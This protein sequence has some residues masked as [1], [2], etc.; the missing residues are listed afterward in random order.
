MSIRQKDT[1][2]ARK[3]LFDDFL[4]TG[5]I[6][7]FVAYLLKK[8]SCEGI[9]AW[10]FAFYGF[11]QVLKIRVNLSC[12]KSDNLV[13]VY[14]YSNEIRQIKFRSKKLITNNITFNTYFNVKI[15]LFFLKNLKKILIFFRLLK[16]SQKFILKKG[17]LVGTRQSQFLY[18]Y[19]FFNDYFKNSDSAL[20]L[21]TF[22]MS[23]ESNPNVIAVGLAARNFGARLAYIN[24]GFLD[25]QLG[26]FFHDAIFVQGEALLERILP[27]I[28]KNFIP[29]KIQIIG[30]PFP[31]RKMIVPVIAVSKIGIVCPL[32]PN[33][34]KCAQLINILKTNYPQVIIDVRLHPNRTFSQKLLKRLKNYASVNI[35][36]STSWS[37][38]YLDWDF[39]FAGNT[40]AHVDLI[41]LGIPALGIQLDHCFEDMYGFYKNGFI[42]NITHFL[43][44]TNQINQFYLSKTWHD[45][46]KRY[47]PEKETEVDFT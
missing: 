19:L 10:V 14:E 44:I 34:D 15:W 26:V 42:L 17:V 38:L 6:N 22:V 20:S 21:K 2:P 41:A 39:A 4:N 3:L 28:R 40:S 23:T 5:R 7:S 25:G 46:Y 1:T 47:I 32:S 36:E 11:F 29:E 30:S 24:H 13:A 16:I 33:V 8:P 12:N 31:V 37:K 27:H 35:V 18:V 9:L 45:I 43:D